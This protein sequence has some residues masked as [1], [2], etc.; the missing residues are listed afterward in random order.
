MENLIKRL[1]EYSNINVV[2]GEE[3]IVVRDVENKD[4]IITIPNNFGNASVDIKVVEKIR[5]NEVSIYGVE[6]TDNE[7]VFRMTDSNIL[8]SSYIWVKETNTSSSQ[9][10]MRAVNDDSELVKEIQELR[11][12]NKELTKKYNELVSMMENKFKSVEKSISD[13]RNRNN[14]NNQKRNE[15]NIPRVDIKAK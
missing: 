15:N 12:E 1:L 14:N 9:P 6:I 2:G 13:M 11:E 8:M 4:Y 3:A 7:I 5:H 10:I